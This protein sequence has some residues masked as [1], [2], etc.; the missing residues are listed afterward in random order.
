M[1]RALERRRGGA[2]VLF[3]SR[4]EVMARGGLEFLLAR[5][6]VRILGPGVRF[7]FSSDLDSMVEM[8]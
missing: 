5:E 2:R 7:F 6:W 8:S 3:P 4:V 1:R